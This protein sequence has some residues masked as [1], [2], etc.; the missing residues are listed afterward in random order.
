MFHIELRQF[1]HSAWRFNLSEAELRAVVVPWARE[2]ARIE[3]AAGAQVPAAAGSEPVAQEGSAVA[4]PAEAPALADPLALGVQLAALLGA[5]PA[6]LLAA[7]QQA[8]AGSPGLSPSE[9]LALAE[10]ALASSGAD[11]R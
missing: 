11:T 9:T 10:R 4:S 2:D 5:Q 6:Q 8:A 3:G 7:W 1:P